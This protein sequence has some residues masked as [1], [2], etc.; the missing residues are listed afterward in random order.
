LD[1]R[2]HREARRQA[3]ADYSYDNEISSV[4]SVTVELR[5]VRDSDQSA[6]SSSMRL[7]RG[8]EVL[9]QEADPKAAT[10]DKALKDLWL[11]YK[12]G[13]WNKLGRWNRLGHPYC[14]RPI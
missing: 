10:M 13:R 14:A 7:F 1:E 4:R 8:A 11:R 9:R 5:L 3:Q 12:V 6:D 2:G